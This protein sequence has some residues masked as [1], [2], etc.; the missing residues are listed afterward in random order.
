MVIR[1]L[2]QISSLESVGVLLLFLTTVLSSGVRTQFPSVI[3]K[4]IRLRSKIDTLI[5]VNGVPTARREANKEGKGKRVRIMEDLEAEGTM[6]VED[7]DITDSL[8][9]GILKE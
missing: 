4:D 6:T 5:G 2:F 7:R 8:H 3:K 1:M 9:S